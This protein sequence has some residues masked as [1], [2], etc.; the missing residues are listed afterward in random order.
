MCTPCYIISMQK[1][2]V[3]DQ[4]GDT[5]MTKV[6]IFNSPKF[7]VTSYGNGLA[8]A[9]VNKLSHREV[10]TQGDDASAFGDDIA[11]ILN[12]DSE[13]PLDDMLTT[14]WGD[15]DSVSLPRE[16]R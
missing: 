14:I 11:R 10:Y 12:D 16:V 9:F 1:D 7:S 4:S 3:S 8:Y 2:T 6:T 5:K 13:R 15:Y